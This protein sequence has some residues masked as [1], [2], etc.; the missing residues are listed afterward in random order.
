M[1][2]EFLTLQRD[3]EAFINNFNTTYPTSGIGLDSRKEIGVCV[4]SCFVI[5][6]IALIEFLNSLD[7][8]VQ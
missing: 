7:E 2:R 3:V 5:I 8:Q 4:P 1:S 6:L